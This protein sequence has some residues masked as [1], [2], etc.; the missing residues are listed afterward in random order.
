MQCAQ[1][2]KNITKCWV[3]WSVRDTKGRVLVAY[4]PK[5]GISEPSED[6]IT[7]WVKRIDKHWGGDEKSL[8]LA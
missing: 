6:D 1:R 5:A 8:K 3:S 7:E 2:L 4:R